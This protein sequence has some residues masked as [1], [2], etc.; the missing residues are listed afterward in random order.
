MLFVDRYNDKNKCLGITK[1]FNRR[2]LPEEFHNYIFI[3]LLIFMNFLDFTQSHL[4]IF[5]NCVSVLN[6]EFNPI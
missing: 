6:A 4:E 5:L 3:T 1:C 2:C